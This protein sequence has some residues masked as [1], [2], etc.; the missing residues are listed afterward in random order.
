LEKSITF[1]IASRYR[2]HYLEGMKKLLVKAF[3]LLIAVL[4][5][6]VLFTPFDLPPFPFFFID[7]AIA[8][9]LLTK[10]LGYLGI[11]IA[12]W[13]PFLKSRHQSK[14]RSAQGSFGSSASAKDPIIDV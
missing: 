1:P 8:L 2:R 5:A 4:S 6:W 7:E 9:V 12:R 13:I 10:S 11:D 14:P 3:A